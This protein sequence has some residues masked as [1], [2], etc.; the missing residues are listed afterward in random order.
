MKALVTGACGFAG[1]YLV[2]HLLGCGDEVLGTV[3]PQVPVPAGG[4]P[5]NAV[6]LDIQNAE[7]CAEVIGRFRPDAVYHLAGLAF[8]PDSES[9]FERALLINVSGTHNIAKVCHLMQSN[10]TMLL[11]SSAEVYGKV[12]EEDLP[13]SEATPLNPANNY[14]LTKVMAEMVIRR[15]AI[16]GQMRGVIVRPFNHIGPRQDSRFVTSS[17]A[18][19]LAQIAAGKSEPILK[20]GNLDAKRDFSD[21]RDIVSGYRKAVLH[22]HG[23]FNLGSGR[24]IAI[25]EVLDTL[26]RIS[27]LSVTVERDPGR[28]RPA[29]VKESYG[30]CALAEHQLGWKREF[31]IEDTLRSVYEY[32]LEQERAA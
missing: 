10:I 27:G 30:S 22:G 2:Q 20:V 1:R 24:S 8:V 16:H 23:T 32:W 6:P 14:S 4:W 11:V 3:L 15:Y 18:R 21:V 26:I 19:Q 5:F 7:A 9:N 28:M 25:Q 13:I 17:F 12:G 29:E 31:S